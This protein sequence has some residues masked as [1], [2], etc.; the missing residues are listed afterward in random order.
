MEDKDSLGRSLARVI[1]TYSSLG[2]GWGDV[3]VIATELR[4]KKIR[5]ILVSTLSSLSLSELSAAQEAAYSALQ[6]P[7]LSMT[8]GMGIAEPATPAARPS[9]RKK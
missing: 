8:G 9:K 5:D 4:N 3:M 6:P 1:E 7:T 2:M